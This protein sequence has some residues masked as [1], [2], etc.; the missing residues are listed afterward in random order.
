MVTVGGQANEGQVF[1]HLAFSS[2]LAGEYHAARAGKHDGRCG[3]R[4]K[5]FPGDLRFQLRT[6]LK[7]SVVWLIGFPSSSLH[8]NNPDSQPLQATETENNSIMPVKHIST[9]EEYNA[10]LETSKTKLVIMDFSADW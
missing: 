3:S 7:L 8:H 10:V 4:K 5:R 2:P 6:S 9:M 1:K